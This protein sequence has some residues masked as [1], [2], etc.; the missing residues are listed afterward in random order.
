MAQDYYDLAD[1]RPRS[2]PRYMPDS[3]TDSES[4][5]TRGHNLRRCKGGFT[6]AD[7]N[8]TQV[9]AAAVVVIVAFFN[10]NFVNCKAAFGS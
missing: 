3:V 1:P 6:A 9:A 7:L 2:Q 8:R 10:D 5:H 4:V